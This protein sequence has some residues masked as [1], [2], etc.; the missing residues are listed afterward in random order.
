M[1]S[2]LSNAA[3]ARL[4]LLLQSPGLNPIVKSP[5]EVYPVSIFVKASLFTIRQVHLALSGV[6]HHVGAFCRQSPKNRIYFNA[7]MQH[8]RAILIGNQKKN[9]CRIPNLP[10]F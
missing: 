10:S 5:R 6:D 9:G 4:I 8:L 7:D 3:I 2:L 1:S